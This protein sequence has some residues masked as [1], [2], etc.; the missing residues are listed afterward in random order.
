MARAALEIGE[1]DRGLLVEMDR[2]IG[3]P[4]LAQQ[5]C[6]LRP[7]RVMAAGDIRRRSRD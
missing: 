7:E 4:R 2:I 3:D 1:Q 6:K 5:L